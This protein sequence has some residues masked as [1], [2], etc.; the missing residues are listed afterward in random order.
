MS[1]RSLAMGRR[2]EHK[3]PMVATMV[4][5]V[6]V[7]LA[8][9]RARLEWA[10]GLGVQIS[11][12]AEGVLNEMSAAGL[13][14]EICLIDG[15]AF[16]R[17]MMPEVGEF[18][19]E[20]QFLVGDFLVNC[21]A[22]LDMTVQAIVDARRVEWRRPEFPLLGTPVAETVS[23]KPAAQFRRCIPEPYQE[24]V[25]SIQ[26]TEHPV[27]GTWTYRRATLE[28]R[29]LSNVNKHRGLTAAVVTR[30]MTRMGKV[31]AAGDTDPIHWL[32]ASESPWRHSSRTV[33]TG[34]GSLRDL[35]DCEVEVLPTIRIDA[36]P[37]TPFAPPGLYDLMD[38]TLR[39]VR[40]AMR[41][42]EQADD[43]ALRGVEPYFDWD[44]IA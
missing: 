29:E 44:A 1:E 39:Y 30:S 37:Q 23:T 12:I 18:P 8:P 36:G 34:K 2:S 25:M 7:D 13:E 33:C 5:G 22:V 24:A 41:R 38:R 4:I 31:R 20:L 40:L 15:E 42:V 6:P 14:R 9:A 3:A 16:A 10:R 26:P 21:R 27:L 43:S 28:L 17:F 35:V 11:S 19:Q 32:E